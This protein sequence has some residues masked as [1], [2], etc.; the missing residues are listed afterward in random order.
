MQ[1]CNGSCHHR[2]CSALHDGYM[3]GM[4]PEGQDHSIAIGTI[5]DLHNPPHH[6][7]NRERRFCLF[8]SIGHCRGVCPRSLR[9][10]T[11]T[12]SG[13][14]SAVTKISGGASSVCE[15]RTGECGG[16]PR[17][18]VQSRLIRWDGI[19]SDWATSASVLWSTLQTDDWPKA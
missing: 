2:E 9:P 16:H 8:T 3:K 6:L 1:C 15:G 11:W 4:P 19:V 12:S 18:P 17:R 7:H 13:D 5:C 10:W 14:A